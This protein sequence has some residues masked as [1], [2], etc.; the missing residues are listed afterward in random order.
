MVLRKYNIHPTF[1]NKNS[2]V[3]AWEDLKTRGWVCTEVT[4]EAEGVWGFQADRAINNH[5][6]EKVK[7]KV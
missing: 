7:T 1:A 6:G 2:A 4:E 3:M 5:Y